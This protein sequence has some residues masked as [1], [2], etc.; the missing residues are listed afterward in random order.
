MADESPVSKHAQKVSAGP[1]E[2]H[3]PRAAKFLKWQRFCAIL[4]RLE[5]AGSGLAAG[6]E[7]RSLLIQSCQGGGF[8]CLVP[9]SG[10]G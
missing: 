7:T 6:P 9:G 10:L 8:L 1:E 3:S 5:A 4:W 2:S